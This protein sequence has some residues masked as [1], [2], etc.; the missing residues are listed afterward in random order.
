MNERGLHLGNVASATA[1]LAGLLLLVMPRHAISILQISITCIG[2]AAGLHALTV[3][4]PPMGWLSPY[5]WMSPFR[6]HGPTALRP[7]RDRTEWAWIRGE[8]S[9]RRGPLRSVS[10]VPPSVLRLLKPI[11][12]AELDLD[13]GAGRRG[14]ADRLSSRA[15]AVLESDPQPL[16]WLR[17]SRPN[18]REVA[19]FVHA[20]LDDLDHLRTGAASHP[21]DPSTRATRR[22]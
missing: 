12:E 22:P 5:K 8:L 10:P 3:H 17:T 7:G 4:V 21:R 16:S 13:R 15:A 9:E 14:A 18:E 6:G 19:A 2:G 11:V 1:F 20:V